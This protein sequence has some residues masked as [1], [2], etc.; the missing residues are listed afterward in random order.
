[1]AAHIAGAWFHMVLQRLAGVKFLSTRR[2]RS[3]PTRPPWPFTAW[4]LTH[5]RLWNNI[6]PRA[7]SMVSTA[8]PAAAGI[9]IHRTLNRVIASTSAQK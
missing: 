7:E 1:M 8:A 3:G 5:A 6:S 4:H 2:P 9:N